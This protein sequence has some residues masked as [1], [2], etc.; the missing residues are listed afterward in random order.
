[1]MSKLGI[2]LNVTS[3]GCVYCSKENLEQVYVKT[4]LDGTLEEIRIR[5]MYCPLCGR[6][7]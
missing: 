7:L 5:P 4:V 3:Q 1:M 2:D 6:K